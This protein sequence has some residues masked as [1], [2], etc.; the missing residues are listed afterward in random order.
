MKRLLLL[1]LAALSGALTAVA[2]DYV[3]LLTNGACD[4]TYN[5]WNVTNGGSGWAI[6]NEEDGT[7]SFV[8]SYKE[9]TLW[10]S[11][12]SWQKN[13]QQGIARLAPKH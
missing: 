5:G 3:E 10:Q 11:S 7:H 12:T 6:E 2:D 9:C 4:G 1:L 13:K 8:S